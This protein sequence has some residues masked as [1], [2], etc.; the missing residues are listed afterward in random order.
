MVDVD[1]DCLEAVAAADVLLPPTGMRYG[2]KSRPVSHR[3][4]RT[5]GSPARTRQ[6]RA[7][8]GEMLVELRADGCQSMAPPSIHPSGERVEWDCFEQPGEML[9]ADLE[10]AVGEVAAATIIAKH[11][12]NEGTFVAAWPAPV[13]TWIG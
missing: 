3:L 7:P 1:L 12:P 10:T 11:W 2:R 6:Y 4:Y 9:T 13:G 8:G 5:T